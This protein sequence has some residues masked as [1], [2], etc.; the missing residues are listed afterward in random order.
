MPRITQFAGL[1]INTKVRYPANTRHLPN[2][3]SMLGQRRRRWASIETSLGKCLVLAGY[4][5]TILFVCDYGVLWVT[6]GFAKVNS[7][8]YSLEK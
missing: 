3:A 6:V 8:N 5:M 2:A 7:R 1:N 4:A